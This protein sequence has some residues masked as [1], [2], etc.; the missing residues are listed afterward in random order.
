MRC[1]HP[2]VTLPLSPP[3]QEGQGHTETT[4]ALP[5]PGERGLELGDTTEKDR[6]QASK[7]HGGCGTPPAPQVTHL[8]PCRT[9]QPILSLHP[10]EKPRA[11]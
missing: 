6:G 1:Q 9:W 7:G 4:G 10:L 8:E 11:A 2:E 5:K 3:S